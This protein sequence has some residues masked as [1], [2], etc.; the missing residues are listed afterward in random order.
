MKSR[1]VLSVL[2]VSLVLL[3]SSAP[4]RHVSAAEAHRLPGMD[5]GAVANGQARMVSG[6][7]APAL[8]PSGAA[9][10]QARTQTLSPAGRRCIEPTGETD[11]SHPS[12]IRDDRF[13]NQ[14]GCKI[15]LREGKRNFGYRHIVQRG[16]EKLAQGRPN[17]HEVTPFAQGL[18]AA[19]IGRPG[20]SLLI[21]PIGFFVASWQY[22][23]GD[24]EQRTMCVFYATND[25]SYAGRSYKVT[26]IVTAYWITGHS[27]YPSQSCRDARE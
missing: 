4:S 8:S 24:G 16:E 19:A 27:P 13:Y 3:L 2:I 21:N 7:L 17:N 12:Y 1:R 23:V 11:P 6:S 22:T 9:S 14:Y 20:G 15:P 18:W 5:V 10:S 26:G 25:L